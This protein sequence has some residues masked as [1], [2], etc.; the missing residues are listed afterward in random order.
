MHDE[1]QPH[2]YARTKASD[3]RVAPS[4]AG[5]DGTSAEGE[6]EDRRRPVPAKPQEKQLWKNLDLS[7]QQIR[8]L[9]MSLFKY[10]FLQELYIC[11]NRLD[12]LTPAIGE[13]RQ[14]R[15]LDASHNMLKDLPPEIGMC[16][17]LKQLLL[18]NNQIHTL[19]H[20]VGSLHHLEQLGIEGNPLD[21]EIM[22][23][24]KEKGTAVLIKDLLE[25]QPGKSL[26]FLV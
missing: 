25:K 11:S 20:E 18:F 12:T 16:T 19:P 10:K 23:V 3:N 13:L 2:Y 6:T 5:A 15:I 22:S 1:G 17:S 26:L 8:S 21:P 7:G 14:L 9:S 24:I 4:A